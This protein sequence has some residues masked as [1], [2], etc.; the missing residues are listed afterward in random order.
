METYCFVG[1]PGGN[2]VSIEAK[3]Y[4]HALQ[5]LQETYPNLQFKSL[6]VMMNNDQNNYD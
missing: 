6:N 2:I 3:N 1:Y 4:G 5:I